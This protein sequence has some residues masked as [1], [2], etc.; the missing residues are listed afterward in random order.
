[1]NKQCCEKCSIQKTD[2]DVTIP[3]EHCSCHLQESKEEINYERDY[4]HIHCWDQMAPPSC[5]IPLEKH[6]QCCL[7]ETKI[8][9]QEPMED[10]QVCGSYICKCPVKE[11]ITQEP[12]EWQ[13]QFL[14]NGTLLGCGDL[15]IMIQVVST[16][17]KQAEERGIEEG[18]MIQR[19]E[20]SECHLEYEKG[21]IKDERERIVK[22]IEE[23][24][25]W[26]FSNME[27]FK[28]GIINLVNQ[29]NE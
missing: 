17:I 8:P 28:Q 6:T 1:M 12:M 14:D 20:L 19:K 10:C 26:N 7:C 24:S 21:L 23:T 11:F 9:T 5:G 3:C 4:S 18:K 13:K 29:N 16:L 2:Q 15:S 27:H 25:I 22:E